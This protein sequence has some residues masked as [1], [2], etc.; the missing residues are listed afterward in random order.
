[1]KIKVLS[2]NIWAGKNLDKVREVLEGQNADIVALQ[3]VIDVP[4]SANHA[5]NLAQSLDYQYV[6]CK[7]FEDD[8]HGGGYSIGN[9]ILSKFKIEESKCVSLSSFD[10]YENNAL[11]EPRSACIGYI[12]INNKKVKVLSVHL[13]YSRTA[14]LSPARAE[15]LKNLLSQINPNEPTILVG[16]LNSIPESEVIKSLDKVLI[17]TDNSSTPTKIDFA[18]EGNPKYK[19]DYIYISSD[20]KKEKFEVLKSDASDH[21]PVVAYLNV[22]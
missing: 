22:F 5:Q 13:G 6:Y 16:D 4:S 9:A 17:N 7:A 21:R 1:M 10:L 12:S 19:I 3:E 2:W 18:T 20:L 15:Q 11:T 14:D 8:R